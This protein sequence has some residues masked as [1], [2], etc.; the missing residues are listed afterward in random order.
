MADQEPVQPPVDELEKELETLQAQAAR[1]LEQAQEPGALEEIRVKVLGR[2]GSLSGF[3]AQLKGEAL[4]PEDKAR[5]GKKLNAVKQ[6]LETSLED[7]RRQVGLARDRP[8]QGLDLTLP[9]IRPQVGRLHP[10]TQTILQI[11]EIFRS[12]G[13]S[14]LEGPEAETEHYNFEALNIPPDHP[15]RENF[16]TF[17]LDT[18]A[19]SRWLLRSHTSPVQIRFMESHRPPF[20]IVVPGRVFRPDAV[21]ASHC[22]Q[23]H[24]VEGL[25]VGSGLTFAD[26]KGVLIAWA[27]GLFGESARLRFRPHYF[28]FTEP[29]A[30]VDLSCIF[31]GAKG[32]RVCGRKGWLEILG[33]GMVHPAVFKAVGLSPGTV[34]F[35][36]GMGV[37][38]IA[39]LRYGI[40]DIRLFFENDLRFL[41]QFP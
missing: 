28:P 24:Q 19:P 14:V 13:F 1:A 25:A 9:G 22:F 5:L 15:S 37:E 26:L 38:R 27:R 41:E 3:F 8:A 31:C 39:M 7:R 12:L 10:V 6:A 16:D 35:A 33:C 17:Y 2:R 32:C 23:F 18:P 20:Q 30:E 21:D 36:F 4:S 34:G 40:E 11:V 29:S